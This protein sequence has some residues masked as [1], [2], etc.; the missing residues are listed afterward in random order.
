MRLA[1]EPCQSHADW[2]FV[3]PVNREVNGLSHLSEMEK[4]VCPSIF[5][6]Y[7]A[8][9]QPFAIALRFILVSV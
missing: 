1:L 9:R 8:S 7:E 6:R 2:A 4:S 3:C 5:N